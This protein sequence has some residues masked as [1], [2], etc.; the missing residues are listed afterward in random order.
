MLLSEGVFLERGRKK[1]APAPPKKTL[2]HRYW[3]V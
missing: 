1:G 2:F 3:L